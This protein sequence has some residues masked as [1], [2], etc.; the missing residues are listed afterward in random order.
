MKRFILLI[1]LL[2]G[3][4]LLVA[5]PKANAQNG[6]PPPNGFDEPG[7]PPRRPNLLQELGLSKDQVQQIRRINIENRPLM[8]ESKRRLDEA[9]LELDKAIY[10][11][12]VNDEEIQI[13]LKEA[14]AAHAEMLKNRTR[15]ETAIRKILTPS[16]LTRFRQLREQF[17]EQKRENNKQNRPVNAQQE[18]PTRLKNLPK[19][20]IFRQP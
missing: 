6:N 14:Q 2:T 20:R 5:I 7:G 17:D 8:Q 12:K 19:R 11:D 13:R 16:Q 3:L 4:V 18:A 9:N 15:Q 1:L 10:D